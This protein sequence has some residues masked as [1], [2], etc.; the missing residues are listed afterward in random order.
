MKN[1][2][3]KSGSHKKQK[4]EDNEFKQLQYECED[5]GFK[6]YVSLEDEIQGV[7][8]PKVYCI[9]CDRKKMFKKRVFKM[10]IKE[11]KDYKDC[12]C[13]HCGRYCVRCGE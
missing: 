10:E 5:C 12:A 6:I 3:K 4:E 8:P 9:N 13:P 2:I 11:Y 1:K 7:C